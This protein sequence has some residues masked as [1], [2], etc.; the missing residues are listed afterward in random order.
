M[1]LFLLPL[2]YST[3]EG[4]VLMSLMHRKSQWAQTRAEELGKA[5][6]RQNFSGMYSQ[7]GIHLKP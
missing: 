4:S 6:V 3:D 5:K 2:G 1:K 7:S